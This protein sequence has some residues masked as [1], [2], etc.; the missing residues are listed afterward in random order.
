MK[1]YL[2][3]LISLFCIQES[4]SYE[5]MS[6]GPM[7]NPYGH[8][9]KDIPS[10]YIE[11]LSGYIDIVYGTS[12]PIV[13]VGCGWG[14]NAFYLSLQGFKKIYAIDLDET[15]LAYL[16]NRAL[17]VN[18][19][20]SI[21]L[22]LGSYPQVFFKLPSEKCSV[23]IFSNVL[24]FMKG[25]E[26]ELALKFSYEDL[27]DAGMIYI[28]VTNPQ[29]D[30]PYYYQKYLDFLAAYSSVKVKVGD[31]NYLPYKQRYFGEDFTLR[32]Y[33]ENQK[34]HLPN[35][36]HHLYPIQVEILLKNIGFKDIKKIQKLKGTFTIIAF[37]KGMPAPLRDEVEKWIESSTSDNH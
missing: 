23:F 6:L 28:N 30:N 5:R 2:V 35:F 25:S 1:Y 15:H 34:R 3:S 24:Q 14:P 21:K 37:K 10:G 36:I 16:K 17:K 11:D 7:N 4:S 32:S 33:S 19:S 31:F 18:R 22:V 27:I 12:L 29:I 26:I 20:Q 13:D 9:S 8:G